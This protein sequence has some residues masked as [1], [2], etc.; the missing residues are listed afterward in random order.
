MQRWVVAFV[1]SAA[2]AVAA[3]GG[4][5]ALGASHPSFAD[6]SGIGVIK[7]E[8]LKEW[9]S[10]VASDELQGRATYG[11]G[12]G[13]AAAYIEQHLRSWGVKPAGDHGGYLQAVRVLGVKTTSRASVTVEVAGE[14]RTFADGDGITL[15]KN[16]GGTRR[17]M[18]DRVEFAG[19]G[20]DAPGAG[21]S[22]YRGKDVRNAAV[23]WLGSSGPKGLDQATYRRLLMG[24]N[25]YATDSSARWRQS[26]PQGREEGRDNREGREGQED[27]QSRRDLAGPAAPANRARRVVLAP[28]A[29]AAV[30][31][32]R[33]PISRRSSGSMRRFRRTSAARTPSS[34]FSSAVRR[35][36]TRR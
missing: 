24:R 12:I 22:D 26:A 7:S 15:P 5:P 32:C 35:N 4:P 9:L 34:S 17:F 29:S 13:L 3:A 36:P 20:L 18:V 19:Y 31:R 27:Q 1:V 28:P 16:M 11:S 33:L 30:R 6:T 2:S 25:R 8:D 23:V 21:H 10:Y 14:T